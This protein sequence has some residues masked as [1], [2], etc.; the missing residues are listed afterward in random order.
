[1]ARRTLSIIGRFALLACAAVPT[2]ATAQIYGSFLNNIQQQ[3]SEQIKSEVE[4][5][6]TETSRNPAKTAARSSNATAEISDSTSSGVTHIPTHSDDFAGK[7]VPKYRLQN[8]VTLQASGG[9]RP[10]D[11][12]RCT[13][14]CFVPLQ[15]RH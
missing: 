4:H 8:G 15:S 12:V 2:V 3:P 11:N 9:F 1:M 13:S 7:H 14:D 6:R 5:P 10:S